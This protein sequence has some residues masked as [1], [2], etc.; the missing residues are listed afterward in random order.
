[1]MTLTSMMYLFSK[2]AFIRPELTPT[3]RKATLLIPH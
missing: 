3:A 2:A 1:M